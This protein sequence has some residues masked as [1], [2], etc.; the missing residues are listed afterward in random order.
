MELSD[1]QKQAVTGWV[2]E[3]AD[4]AEIQ[5]RLRNEFGIN[6]TYMDVRFLLVDLEATPRDKPASEAR[7]TVAA[8]PPGPDT[9]AEGADSGAAAGNLLDDMGGTGGGAV[10]VSF[11]KVVQPGAIVSGSATFSDGVSATWMLDQMGRLALNAAQP[12][13]RPSES[14]LQKFQ[15][16]LRNG[17]QKMGY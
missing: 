14:D 4:V 2:A 6:I 13:Y 16:E 17:L 12:G 10:S 15:V 11:D 7:Q 9:A 1:V 3:G 5:E 8:P